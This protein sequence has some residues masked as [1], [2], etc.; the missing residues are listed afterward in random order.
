MGLP[1][2]D[3][4]EKQSPAEEEF[5][6]PS[7][8]DS[9]EKAD[10]IEAVETPFT[11]ISASF[12]IA[13]IDIVLSVEIQGHERKFANI[14]LHDFVL[15][16]TNANK[17]SAEVSVILGGLSVEDLLHD[18]DPAYRFLL[19]SSNV[20]TGDKRQ[21][22]G[23]STRL[24]SSCP[25]ASSFS[26]YGILSTSLP[27][28]LH[29]SPKRLYVTSPLRPMIHSGKKFPSLPQLIS[30]RDS[31]S[32]DENEIEAA[33]SDEKDDSWVKINVLLI[34]EELKGSEENELFV[35]ITFFPVIV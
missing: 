5:V 29:N 20:D 6:F 4:S 13:G 30:K 15:G 18:G 28:V 31:T 33:L 21:N 24:S 26:D 7:D 32:D 10:S 3:N 22:L 19:K 8:I 14:L 27:S 11:R 17:P 16:Y 35:R 25:E 9:T 1:H 2:N 34:D 12:E 23:V